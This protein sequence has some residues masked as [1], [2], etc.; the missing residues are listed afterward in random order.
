MGKS[1]VVVGAQ[2]G[3]EGKGKVIDLLA[4]DAHAVVRFQGGH[5]AG[6]TVVVEERSIVLHLIP[7]GI[8]HEHAKC[9]IGNGVVVSPHA[10]LEEIGQLEDRGV[11]VRA[12]L[13]ISPACPLVLPTHVALDLARENCAGERKIGTTGRGIGPAYE[14]KSAR[15]AIRVGDLYRWNEAVEQIK[16][17]VSYHNFLLGEYYRAETLDIDQILHEIDQFA[18]EIR[19]LVRDTLSALHEHRERSDNIL[20]EGA[21]GTMLDVDLGT[22]PFVT[23]SHAAAGGASV[24]TGFGPRYFDAVLGVTKAYATRVGEGPFPTELNDDRGTRLAEAGHELGATTGR[25]RR[26]GWLDLV[27]LKHAVRMNSISVLGITK[28]DVLGGFD[29]VQVCTNYRFQDGHLFRGDFSGREL[30]DAEPEYE[31][32]DGWET[33]IEDIGHMDDLPANATKFVHFIEDELSVPVGLISTGRDRASTIVRD[34]TLF[35]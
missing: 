33:N 8:L 26:C 25:P 19:P 24:G 17:L 20:F 5:N 14:D 1:V 30:L 23:S 9:Y 15:R 28:M 34:D 18:R 32:L 4:S 31:D 29:K 10:L 16:E 3:D 27:A 22:Y 12:R 6:H 2:W 7:S 21:Q 35:Q 13:S 11:N